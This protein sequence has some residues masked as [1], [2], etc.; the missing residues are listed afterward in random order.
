MNKGICQDCKFKTDDPSL[1]RHPAVAEV[2]LSI[3]GDDPFATNYTEA[4]IRA[5]VRKKLDLQFQPFSWAVRWC[6]GHEK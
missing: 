4:R 1:C 5:A 2:T 3:Q 6:N